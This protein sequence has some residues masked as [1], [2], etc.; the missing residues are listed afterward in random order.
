MCTTCNMR[1][2]RWASRKQRGSALPSFRET[3]ATGGS[4]TGWKGWQAWLLGGPLIAPRRPPSRRHLWRTS[5]PE[6]D[7]FSPQALDRFWRQDARGLGTSL[8]RTRPKPSK[9]SGKRTLLAFLL[10]PSNRSGTRSTPA[11]APAP[12][13][14]SH[15]EIRSRPLEAHA[16]ISVRFWSGFVEGVPHFCE[17]GPS[18]WSVFPSLP[19]AP[20]PRR[21]SSRD[22][23]RKNKCLSGET[24][25]QK[26]QELRRRGRALGEVRGRP[27][28]WQRLYRVVR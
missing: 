10:S 15:R 1:K 2:K 25:T 23:S 18:V 20:P 12:P 24:S 11:W 26:L 21:S 9:G 17:R 6:Q 22:S 14:C 7:V 8:P 19:V 28:L 16:H 27:H 5:K 13:T 4:R 3:R